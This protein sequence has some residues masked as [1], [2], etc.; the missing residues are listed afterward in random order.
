M[1][2]L[3]IFVLAV[4]VVL[5]KNPKL[6][7]KLMAGSGSGL[8]DP[9]ILIAAGIM[10]F[11]MVIWA[12][13]PW[14]WT[15][16]I[17]DKKVFALLNVGLWTVLYLRTIK[18][19]DSTGKDIKEI[20]PTASILANIIAV[21][22]ALGLITTARNYGE[23]KGWFGKN[24][25]TSS[26]QFAVGIDQILE[27]ICM[28]ESGGRQF[29]EDGKTPLRGKE[30]PNDVGYC[31]INTKI[32]ESRIKKFD[33]DILKSKEDNFRFARGL[34]LE[35]GAGP[36]LKSMHLWG[37]KVGQQVPAKFFVKPDEWSHE[38][39]LPAISVGN[40]GWISYDGG[41]KRYMIK[42]ISSNTTSEDEMPRRAGVWKDVGQET[43]WQ[44]KSLEAESVLITLIIT[45]AF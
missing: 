28:A 39:K 42:R 26:P 11:D 3:I 22:L 4:V 23:E 40:K 12:M 6:R 14:L 15:I 27:Q 10:V 13:I 5:V 29:E 19:K 37:P 36:W 30:D 2:W 44:F 31:Q 18:V 8:T 17:H 35:F 9:K 20:N 45:P 32:W 1:T 21:M 43:S 25:E 38:I 7:A 16:L 24:N 34:Y 33:G 41:G